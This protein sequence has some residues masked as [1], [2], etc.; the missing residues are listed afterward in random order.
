MTPKLN[1][2]VPGRELKWRYVALGAVMVTGLIL[3]LIQLYRL[4]VVRGEEF[5][6]RSVANFVKETRILADRGMIKDARGQILVQNRPSFDVFV[7][8]AFCQDCAAS[9]M[10]RL[11]ELLE[12]DPDQLAKA[13]LDLKAARRKAP[14]APLPVQVD[15]QRDA[16]DLLSGHARE[17]PGV[18]VV[19]VPHRSYRTGTVLAHVLG[20]M[21]EVST[22]ELEKDYEDGRRYHLGDYVGRAGLER[23]FESTLR[24][25]D[26]LRRM[27]VDARGQSIPDLQWLIPEQEKRQTPGNNIVLSIDLRL[28]EE[29]ER[30]FPGVAGAVIVVDVHT[31]FIRAIV[32]RPS[33]DPNVLTGR[34]T[35][36]QMDALSRDPLR[37]MVF[38]PTADHFSPGST[39]K[40]LT[41]LAAL[42]SGQFNEHS[43]AMCSGGYRLGS[44]T[45]RCHSAHG[46]GPVNA[47]S[48]IKHSCNVY[49]Y[50]VADTLGLDAI[51]EV[52]R[53]F[54]L[55]SPTGIG[56]VSEVPGIMPTVA[57]HEQVNKKQGGYSRG[58]ALNSS[59][60]QGA[61]TAT[62]LQIAMMFAALA[63]GGTVYVPQL[64]TAVES[65]EGRAIEQFEP[66][67]KNVAKM[68]PEQHEI[69]VSALSRV[70][71]EPGGTAY[72]RRLPDIRVAGK[73]GTA[74]V[75]RIGAIR[76]KTHQQEYWQR[77]HAWFAAFAPDDKPEIAVVV[78]NEHGG[79]GG[80]AAAPT[81]MAIIQKY[82]DL[83]REDEAQALGVPAE[84]VPERVMQQ[85]EP[86]RQARSPLRRRPVVVSEGPEV[87]VDGEVRPIQSAA[88]AATNAAPG[89]VD[90]G[91][92]AD[93]ALDEVD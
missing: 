36:A 3:L 56:V 44:R 53:E 59:V 47:S 42:R 13:Q 6:A 70:V 52:G 12:W 24:G 75:A 37:P 7:T 4:Q 76:L 16:L 49:F 18:E 78:L 30:L 45:W 1:R 82:F 17:L 73:T 74:Q 2:S 93:V 40:P 55:G 83:K 33:F 32:S 58:M 43:T 11:G 72:R 60:G 57:W 39:F 15:I 26:G 64:V 63:N 29:A 92:P 87:T 80:T 38:R 5:A 65:P 9:V 62:P 50:K 54:G 22:R 35:R 88:P 77:D 79:G 21:N 85:I 10:P 51:A 90:P 71:N 67:V 27:V 14:F 23:S 31:G 48:S 19:A 8:P 20:Y 66:K 91:A 68:T 84:P 28:Q 69:I 81:A 46:H 41:T 89:S 34:V 86:P 61:N 25:D